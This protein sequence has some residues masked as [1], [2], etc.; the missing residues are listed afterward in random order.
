MNGG[1]NASFER[2]EMELRPVM[3]PYVTYG[4]IAVNIIIW[5]LIT[6]Y[7]FLAGLEQAGML[8]GAKI[9]Q[10]IMD[11]QYWRF[12]TPVFL[13][14]GLAHIAVNSY[15]LYALGPVVEILYGR[16]R[17][18][19]IYLTAGI[20][21][22]VASFAFS[23]YPSVGA[24]GAIF[25]LLGAILFTL[26]KNRHIL[27]TSYGIGILATI[28]INIS[29]GFTHSGI[30]NYA[31]LGGLVGGFLTA[32][33]LGYTGERS[34]PLRRIVMALA[35]LALAAGGVYRGFTSEEN[36]RLYRQY[37]ASFEER[38]AAALLNDALRSFNDGNYKKSEELSRQVL[39]GY[40]LKGEIRAA[41]LDL[42]ASSLINTG[43]S[44]Q[45]VEY[46][47]ELV[48]IAPSRGHYLLGT[49]YYNLGNL[50]RAKEELEEAY[51]LDPGNREVK[52]LLDQVLE[53]LNLTSDHISPYTACSLFPPLQ[54]GFPRVYPG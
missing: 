23:P 25:G 46:A 7:E 48:K 20:V 37:R 27:K 11:G 43:R 41:A 26:F 6:S 28:L 49:C 31:H 10:L 44:A 5:L 36:T 18:L 53:Y 12:I 40:D 17:F 29:Y 39:E 9:N 22:N 35:V 42:L 13:H 2:E 50:A 15:S 30:D 34:R 14:A 4:L 8:F 16:T 24:S 32:S 38:D 51:K 3:R 19:I 45:A 21:G 47:E 52:R 54:E 33:A 1:E